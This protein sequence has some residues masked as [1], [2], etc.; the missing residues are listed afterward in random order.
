MCRF[1]MYLGEPV[2]LSSLVTEPRHSI[3]HQS[4]KAEEREEPLNGDGFGVAWYT[5]HIQ[6]EPAIFKDVSPAW[7]NQNLLHLAPVIE[8]ECLL[9]HVR[10]AT[11]GLPVS[12]LNCHP[13]AWEQL[14]FMHNGEIAAFSEIRRALRR[15][16]SDSAYDW[17]KGSTDTEHLFALFVDQYRSLPA[18]DTV[19]RMS[20]ALAATVRLV[21]DMTASFRGKTPSNLNLVVTDGRRAVVSRYSSDGRPPNTLYVHTDCQYACDE[22]GVGRLVPTDS[23][24][25][26]IASE[27]LTDDDSWRC[28]EPNHMVLVDEKREVQQRAIDI[29]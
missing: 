14:A 9:A 28:V 15:G 24:A 4:Y 23:G 26:L 1:V 21:E 11:P 8:S 10:A 22:N 29:R 2:T 19:I 18:G 6:P 13:F 5:P 3:I 20:T 17:I 16:L 25:V 12:E 7:N 27:P